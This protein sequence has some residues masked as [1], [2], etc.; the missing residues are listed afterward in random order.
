[1]LCHAAL[2]PQPPEDY[3]V[4]CGLASCC[5][6]W[7]ATSSQTLLNQASE[8]MRKQQK[9]LEL[10]RKREL[11]KEEERA[12]QVGWFDDCTSFVARLTI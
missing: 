8:A 6:C 9:L 1:M 4:Y 2:Q 11:A 3:L 7:L 12:K 5:T 10:A